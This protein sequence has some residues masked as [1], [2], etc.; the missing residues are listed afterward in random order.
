[1]E[2][3]EQKSTLQPV[4]GE[5]FEFWLARSSCVCLSRTSTDDQAFL[6]PPARP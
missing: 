3:K 2:E 5:F 4:A 6:L 1:M